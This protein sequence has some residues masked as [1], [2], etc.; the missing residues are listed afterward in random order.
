MERE[1]KK[2]KEGERSYL[3]RKKRKRRKVVRER[4]I[5]AKK[6]VCFA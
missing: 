5:K 6:R 1:K 3:L 4:E 2:A